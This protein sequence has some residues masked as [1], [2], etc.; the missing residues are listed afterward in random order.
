MKVIVC[1]AGQVGFNIAKQLAAEH[2]DVT[3]IDQSRELVKRVND[4]L[5]V[6]SIVGHA[7]R[8]NVL[9]QAGANE[10][11]MIVAVTQIDEINM[12]VCQVAHSLFN[13]S[14]RIARVRSQEY[15]RPEWSNL[16]SRD[17]MPIDVVISPEV[18]IARAVTR[19]LRAPGAINMIPFANDSVRVMG[20]LIDEGCPVID[21]P[22]RQLTELFP[23]LQ[24]R[25]MGIIRKDKI[26]VPHGDEEI[27]VG[28]EVYFA[29]ETGHMARAMAAFG[30]EEKE[31]HRVII[32]GGGSV[33][34]F[35]AE[36]IERDHP[37]VSLK[38]IESEEE[39]AR[40]LAEHV[41]RSVVLHGNALDS[42]LLEEAN[43]RS[44]ETV[45]AVTDDDEVN[46][47]AS[48]LAK[49]QGCRRAITLIN[50]PAYGALITSLG[51]DVVVDPRAITVSSI[52]QYV[53]RGRI[54]S[55]HSL[56]DGMAELIEGDALETSS[57][58]GA[59]LREVKVPEGIVVGAIVRGEEVIIPRGSTVIEA[60]DRVILFSSAKVIKS[61][62]KMFSVRLDF[63]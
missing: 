36:Q 39:R 59:P 52:L 50:D 18:E 43:A 30:H 14:T 29:V 5:D 6:K 62:E 12:M 34:L 2:N 38:I 9:S 11:D 60:D 13:V 37:G 26:R 33:G 7:A 57:L 56:R 10:A 20:L 42:D 32:L 61:A 47:L 21:T 51:I 17:H 49:R 8:P 31:A 25:I 41:S 19:R 45:V 27:S 15:L 28:D 63:F 3:V 4:Q 54:R 1:G 24:I 46:I 40:V 53:R 22:L 55:V 23:G 44:A 16:F 35:L 48:L 58:V